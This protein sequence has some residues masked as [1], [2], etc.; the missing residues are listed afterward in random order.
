MFSGDVVFPKDSA[1]PSWADYAYA[2]TL[3]SA[4]L[5]GLQGTWT[6]NLGAWDSFMS[7]GP[8]TSAFGEWSVARFRT[9]LTNH[10]TL[11]QLQ[12]WGVL[13]T[14]STVADI[15]TF[16]VRTYFRNVASNQFGLATTNLSDS[17]WN[18]SAW[19]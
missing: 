9:Y 7:G 16:D 13:A 15:L 2:S 5:T 4:Q 6:D 1:C 12:N 11:N 14:N 8:V 19:L 10:F 3:A 18:N 17:A